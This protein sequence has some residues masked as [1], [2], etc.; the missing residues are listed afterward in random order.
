MG[1]PEPPSREQT[2]ALRKAAWDTRKEV[3][4]ADDAGNLTLE[5]R[6]APWSL[7]LVKEF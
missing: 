7:V 3:V 2:E 4:R 1:K 6:I 5:R